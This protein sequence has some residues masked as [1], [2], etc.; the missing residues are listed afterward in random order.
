MTSEV[1][2][3]PDVAWLAGV[4]GQVNQYGPR[5]LHRSTIEKLIRVA[6]EA[7]ELRGRLEEAESEIARLNREVYDA[8]DA[9]RGYEQGDQR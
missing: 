7:I 1:K 3:D 9:L 6:G 8:T 2:P 4:S 5:D